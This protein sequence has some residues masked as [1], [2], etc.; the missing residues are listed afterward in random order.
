MFIYASNKTNFFG[1]HFYLK[2]K[3]KT[4]KLLQA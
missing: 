1:F 4:E 2:K 3:N